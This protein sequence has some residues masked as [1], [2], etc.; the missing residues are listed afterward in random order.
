M[1]PR[2]TKAQVTA[3]ILCAVLGFGA[4]TQV[5]QNSQ[6]AY[7][8]ARED[9][10]VWLLDE[11]NGRVDQLRQENSQLEAQKSQLTNSADQ[12]AAAD[13]AAEQRAKTQGILA[14]TD[15]ATGPGIELT[16][17]DPAGKV[18]A[19]QL[20]HALEEL[21]NA[22]AEAITLGAQRITASSWVAAGRTATATRPASV[23]VDGTS[24]SAPYVFDAIGDPD[25]LSVALNIPGGVL[26]Q[27]TAAGATYNLTNQASLTITAVRPLATPHYASPAPTH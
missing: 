22:G 23:D 18:T 17:Y 13:Q 8:N 26:K 1:R 15:P 3:A 27:V 11:L 4:V 14:G 16:I 24:V 21:R 5:H 2:F 10:L 6:S 20:Y 9:D 25:T 12:A 7:A 19:A